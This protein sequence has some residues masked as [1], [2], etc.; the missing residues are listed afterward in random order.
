MSNTKRKKKDQP[1]TRE[2]LDRALGRLASKVDL[3]KLAT[4]AE[5][6]DQ[7]EELAAMV[8]RGFDEAQVQRERIDTRQTAQAK[9][10]ADI[11]STLSELMRRIRAYETEAVVLRKHLGDLQQDVTLLKLRPRS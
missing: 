9:D 6:K 4:R 10:V 7:L 8:K 11:A 2:Y 5:L 3:A 1:L